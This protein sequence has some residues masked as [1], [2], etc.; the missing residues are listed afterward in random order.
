MIT[1]LRRIA[2]AAMLLAPLAA[3]PAHAQ[4]PEGTVITNT[5]TASWTDANGNTYTPATASVSVTVGYKAAPDVQSPVT[6]T[7]ATPST[8]NEIPFTIVNSGNGTDQFSAAISAGAGVTVTGY[9]IGS[10]T[11]ATL[12]ELNTA[13]AATNVTSGGNVVVSVVYTTAPG[14]GGQTV[15]VT[16]TATSVRT[17]AATGASDAS[18]TNVAP[19]LS[20]DVVVTPDGGVVPRLPN[21]ATV[22]T[23]SETF[24][25]QNNGN[26]SDTYTLAASTSTGGIVTIVSVNGTAGA[27]GSVTVNA[28]GSGSNT[29][30]VVVVYTV[31]N[32]AA[33]GATTDLRLLATSGNDAT[34]SDQ[35]HATIQVIRATIT[36]T[37]EA[38]RD[39][40][41]T[42]VGAQN[43]A[44]GVVPGDYMWYKITVTNAGTAP[45]T[46]NGTYG[47]TDALPSQVTYVS[48]AD[49]GV[50]GWTISE[51]SGTVTAKLAGTLAASASRFFWIRVRIN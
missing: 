51:T 45:A 26:R 36:M 31:S 43:T 10:T 37:K 34:K 20:T 9:K 28:A 48:T 33:T 49:D 16:L 22:T 15:P 25:V 41:T 27:S 50:A 23:Y 11:Y 39:D 3:K 6:V 32:A 47:V 2:L 35:G 7:P 24:V 5:A 29:Q 21:S 1:T 38:F 42:P 17:P 4:T 19:V 18:T 30:N 14:L 13:L 44:N 12:A 46:L 40:Q 8:G